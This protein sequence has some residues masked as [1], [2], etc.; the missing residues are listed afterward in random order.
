MRDINSDSSNAP[1][2]SPEKD[3]TLDQYH[4]WA[5]MTAAY[6]TPAETLDLPIYTSLKL[7]GEAGEVAEKVGKIMRDKE[8]KLDQSDTVELCKEL[9]DVLWYVSRMADDLGVPLSV[10]AAMNLEKLLSRKAR[11]KISGEGDDR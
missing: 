4:H 11:G 5:G 10:V 2:L 9:G 3:M 1:A 6:P 7:A 8:G